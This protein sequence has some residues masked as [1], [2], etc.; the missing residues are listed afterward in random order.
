[1]VKKLTLVAALLGAHVV[2]AQ[3]ST[4]NAFSLEVRF[5]LNN[6]VNPI[7][8]GYDASSLGLMHTGVGARYMFNTKFGLRL[9]AGYDQL[10]SRPDYSKDF[11]TNHYAMNLEGVMNAGNVLH[12]HNW[13]RRIGLMVHA[14]AGYSIMNQKDVDGI[15]RMLQAT[16][17]ITPMLRLNDRLVLSLDAS[18]TAHVY[19][20]RT[21]DFSEY[22]Y[23][24]G[25]DGYL[26]NLSLGI[27]YNFGKGIH[28][29]W[30]VPADLSG[31]LKALDEKIAALKEQQK[32]D[33][34]D[35]VANYLDEE[36]D[37]AE[38]AVVDTKGRTQQPEPK[39]AD[40]DG[41]PDD[42]DDCPFAKG[43]PATKGCPDA[44]GDGIA[45][46]A[47]ECPLLAGTVSG[48]GCPDISAETAAALNKASDALKFAPGK[49]TL[50]AGAEAV[51]ND[52]V[53][54]LQA[55]PEYKLQIDVHSGAGKDPLRQLE[56]TQR[57][58]DA[59]RYY[60]L[61]K[62]IAADRVLAFGFGQTQPVADI[63]TAEGNARNERTQLRIRF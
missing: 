36:P 57:R 63:T 29:D 34:H 40:A 2:T 38:G 10:N 32:D 12:F 1:M 30:V 44:D 27:Q 62:G 5:G 6:P 23:K 59:V 53:R 31:R 51:L 56:L 41:V 58:A 33:D 4:Q 42:A 13:T 15:D 54:Q 48:K 37:T 7:A 14:G 60:L 24:R 20:T 49:H 50:P 35:G 22:Y 46:R 45:D 47:D 43:T 61:G 28:R 11:R 19:Q 26:F 18:A 39:D 17:G 55:H 16:A 25:V 21:Y 52:V 9:Y 3:D 8:S